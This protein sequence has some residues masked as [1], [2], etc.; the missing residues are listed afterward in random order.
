MKPF[1]N[2]A[3]FYLKT[4]QS[5][6]SKK[7]IQDPQYLSLRLSLRELGKDL[8]AHKIIAKK[9]EAWV[10]QKEYIP[11]LRA[12]SRKVILEKFKDV[13]V[14]VKKTDLTSIIE[15]LPKKG[16]AS[17]PKSQG[18]AAKDDYWK[19]MIKKEDLHANRDILYVFGDNM[20]RAGRG[21]Q[22]K[23]MRDEFNAI[24]IPTKHEPTMQEKAFFKD[25]DYEKVSAVIEKDFDHI[26]NY[27][28]AGG[29][30][31]F[32]VSGIGTGLA[33]LP[34]KSPKIYGLIVE[35]M[36]NLNLDAPLK[37]DNLGNIIYAGIGARETPQDVLK[38]M[39]DIGEALA[40]KGYTL[41]SGGAEGADS[42]FENGQ[43][44][45]AGPKEIFI[46]YEGFKGRSGK[47][48]GVHVGVSKAALEMAA[49]Y[50]PAW[51][52]CDDRAQKLH[53]RNGYQMLGI[54][55]DKKAQ[56]VVCFTKD[57]LI[58]GGTGQ[59]LRIAKDLNIPAVNLGD[60]KI[61]NLTVDQ[62]VKIIEEKVKMFDQKIEEKSSKRRDIDIQI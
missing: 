34:N 26:R 53:G 7:I 49:K 6:D 14:N 27:M 59:A 2:A 61:K 16:V 35:N 17:L 55:L 30:V 11:E 37:A 21:G 9:D 43:N 8:V 22:A 62:V 4:L 28:L 54:N 13:I 38:K 3:D 20:V 18:D 25:S 40:K 47:E 42:A 5:T 23:E 56:V 12:N 50:H 41:R 36:N 19:N 57:G 32:P 29:D 48:K 44:R 60:P 24:G 1:Y 10:V 51:H 15:N 39:E 31:K 58:Q 52:K 45:A 46:P 33:D